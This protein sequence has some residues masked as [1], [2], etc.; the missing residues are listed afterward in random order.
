LCE[1]ISRFSWKEGK[2]GGPQNLSVLSA[3][4]GMIK[5]E[6]FAGVSHKYVVAPGRG[7]K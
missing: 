7:E 5:G 2:C 4:H 6:G 1:K 3:A